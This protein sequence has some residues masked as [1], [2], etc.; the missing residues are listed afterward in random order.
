MIKTIQNRK[1]IH[2]GTD[3]WRGLLYKEVNPANISRVAQA[4]ADYLKSMSHEYNTVAIGYDGRKESKV[5]ATLFAKVLSGNNIQV[6]LSSEVIPTPVLSF[7]T[8]SNKYSAGVMITASH[9][10]PEYNG[11]KFKSSKGSPFATG[12]TKKVENFLDQNTPVESNEKV[13]IVDMLH[14]Y[15]AHL[16][17]IIDFRAVADSGISVAVDSMGG[18]GGSLLKDV[19]EYNNVTVKGIYQEPLPDFGGRLAEPIKKNLKPLSDLL[20]KGGCA[21]GVATDGDADRLGVM[22]D[23][24]EWM[25]I[26]ETIL[27]LGQ[28]L[29]AQKE[30]QGDFVKTLSVTDKFYELAAAYNFKIKEVQVGFKYVAEKMIEHNAVFGA[31][32]SGG[33]GFKAHLPERDGIFSAL[34][35][36][37]MVSK[38]GFNTLTDFIEAKRNELGEIYYDRIDIQYYE[39]DFDILLAKIFHNPP[40]R[41]L[42]YEIVSI[43][44]HYS[45][46]NKIN[47]LK[48]RLKK[49]PRWLLLRT[50]ET[51]PVVRIYAEGTST[52]EV[53]A[54]L[55]EGIRLVELNK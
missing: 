47:S 14:D 6:E 38:S 41:I 8:T 52:K 18:A 24:G 10:P 36:I 43:A 27:F 31:E 19:L 45:A 32:E 9:N 34:L 22:T 11:V 35:F 48:F 46:Q 12:E 25:N 5:Y 3:G 4:F 1:D 50:S 51:E 37:E 21:L 53:K 16:Q 7:H 55:D 2:F 40:S 13:K 29:K 26:Q 30:Q 33:F 17:N 49:T 39:K 42:N 54:L 20:R 23:K 15:R 44:E 28:F